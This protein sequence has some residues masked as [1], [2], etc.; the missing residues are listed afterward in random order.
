M[1]SSKAE[2]CSIFTQSAQ[3]AF[4][5]LQF[6]VHL[7]FTKQAAFLI[8]RILEGRFVCL[9]ENSQWFPLYTMAEWVLS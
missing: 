1:I 3:S 4:D 9:C 5:L 7:Y 8:K 6:H 2:S